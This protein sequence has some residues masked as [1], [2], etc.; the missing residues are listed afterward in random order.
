MVWTVDRQ[1]H[2][3]F[4]SPNI[5][6]MTGYTAAELCEQGGAVWLD[7]VHEDD[8]ERVAKAS[9]L[10]FTTGKSYDM[11]Y[12]LRRKD[13]EWFWA[14]GRS[15]FTFEENGVRY[16]NGLLSDISRRKAADEAGH[17]L[18]A[19]VESSQDAITGSTLDGVVTS[20]NPGAEQLYGYAAAEALGR[21]IALVAPPEKQEELKALQEAVA[22]GRSVTVETQRLRKD[23]TI[24]EVS[25]SVSPIKNDAGKITGISG[26]ARD[27]TSRKQADKQLRLQSAAL[28]AAANADCHYRPAGNHRMGQ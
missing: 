11:E 20:W 26:I 28:E 10:L 12:R 17:R 25:L 6:K 14:H 5:E 21:K 4:V 22:Q 2:I 18:G 16:A 24:V 1:Q 8:R 13:G 15:V 9:D 27:I 19:I 7:S 3:T 23:G